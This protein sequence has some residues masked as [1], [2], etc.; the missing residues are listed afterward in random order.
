MEKFDKFLDKT[1]AKKATIGN[2]TR[3]KNTE[4]GKGKSLAQNMFLNSPLI[5]S[6]KPNLISN[7]RLKL[8]QIWG[9]TLSKDSWRNLSEWI[10]NAQFLET[11]AI[12]KC[13]LSFE[14][15]QSLEDS[16]RNCENC[17]TLDLRGNNIPDSMGGL[18]VRIMQAQTEK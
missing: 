16:L 10:S 7:K 8:L 1:K 18:I 4:S 15:L 17:Q 5:H 3:N 14:F 12:N 2:K 13:S 9:I 11:L 6:L